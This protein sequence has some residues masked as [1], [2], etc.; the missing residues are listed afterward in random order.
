MNDL[1]ALTP[2]VFS[3]SHKTL[4]F[5][6]SLF[7]YIMYSDKYDSFFFVCSFKNNLKIF[8]LQ[9]MYVILVSGLEPS[10]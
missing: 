9:L 8:Q 10:D 6:Q 7:S 2:F 1:P 4:V 5:W 3:H